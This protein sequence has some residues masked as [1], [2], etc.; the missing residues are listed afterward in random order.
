MDNN[1]N[2]I[3]TVF[4]F[5]GKDSNWSEAPDGFH[6]RGFLFGDGLFETMIYTDGRLRFGGYHYERLLEGCRVLNLDISNL[7]SI[8]LIENV[9]TQNFGLALT[10]RVRWNVY[11]SGMGKYTP[12]SEDLTESLQLQPFIPPPRIKGKAFFHDAI[13]VQKSVWSHCKTLNALTYVMANLERKKNSMDEVLICNSDGYVSEAGSSNIFWV[14]EGVFF[15]PSLNCSCIA[16]VGRRVLIEKLQ[17]SDIITIEG[18]FLP[19]DIMEADF[20]FTTNVT[21]VSFIAQIGEVVFK[22][23]SEEFDLNYLDIE[24]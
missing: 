10:L 4:L 9:L 7:S 13:T 20:V 15:T 14:K 2:G 19:K 12:E 16:G 1:M 24:I 3:N 23:K 11:R 8:S 21:G 6:N 17:A 5:K 22:T 18:E